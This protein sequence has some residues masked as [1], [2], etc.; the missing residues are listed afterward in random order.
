MKNT[1]GSLTRLA[2]RT[3]NDPDVKIEQEY[4]SAPLVDVSGTVGA[5]VSYMGKKEVFTAAQL[6]AMFLTRAKQT[7]AASHH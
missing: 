6:C 4:V 3:I 7:A 2:G 5:E 1:V